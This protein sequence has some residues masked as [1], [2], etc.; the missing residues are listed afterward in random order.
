MN[1]PMTAEIRRIDDQN[2]E[3]YRSIR[4]AALRNAPE[5]FGSTYDEEVSRPMSAFADR[6]R[7][8]TVF[9]A[10][11]DAR[12]VGMVGFARQS[13]PKD[14]HKGFLWGMYVDPEMR[15]RGIG[16]ALVGAALRHAAGLVEQV[17]L[18]VVTS[19]TSAIALY[20]ALGFK[21]YGVE[22]RALKSA[23]GCADEMLMLRYCDAAD[24]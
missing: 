22:P 18:S 10:Y 12:V 24:R 4:L 13:G 9:G 23:Q 17:T 11:D 19:N 2:V 3:D 20:E 1:P 5:A 21:P 14:R 8:T 6:L 15:G 16:A 7:H